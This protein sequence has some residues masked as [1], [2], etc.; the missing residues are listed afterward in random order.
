MTLLRSRKSW[1]DNFV[2]IPNWELGNVSNES[3]S[4]F[5]YS[6]WYF[7]KIKIAVVSVRSNL[8][9]HEKI[10]CRENSKEK[11]F[12]REILTFLSFTMLS[13]IRFHLRHFRAL[14]TV[15]RRNNWWKRNFVSSRFP[16]LFF[17]RRLPSLFVDTTARNS[18]SKF[19]T[20]LL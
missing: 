1:G 3:Y 18:R 19:W 7:F 5:P 15:Y 8:S 9:F 4:Y 13:R 6:E 14:N 20:N 2:G 11:Q 12:F 17:E 10:S 16:R